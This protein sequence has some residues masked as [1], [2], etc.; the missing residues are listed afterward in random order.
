MDPV[1]S[2][3]LIPILEKMDKLINAQTLINVLLIIIIFYQQLSRRK[4]KWIKL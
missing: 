2:N 3:D 1:T 4:N